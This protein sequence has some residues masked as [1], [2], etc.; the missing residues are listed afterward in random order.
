[1][2]GFCSAAF[3]LVGPVFIGEVA[4][5]KVVTM[6]F[7]MRVTMMVTLMTMMV[8]MMVMMMVT[9]MIIR[10]ALKTQRTQL[11]CEELFALWSPS[12]SALAFS[13]S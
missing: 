13:L 2:T 4:H 1:M 12:L 8:T 3:G 10:G 6:M 5:P 7:T 9:V 11:R